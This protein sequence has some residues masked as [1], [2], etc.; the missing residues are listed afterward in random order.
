MSTSSR[1]INI[2]HLGRVEGHGGIFIKLA[3][4]HVT[5]VNLDVHEGSRYYEALLQA[6]GGQTAHTVSAGVRIAW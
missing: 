4:D 5:E 1:T 3:G 2:S 6:S